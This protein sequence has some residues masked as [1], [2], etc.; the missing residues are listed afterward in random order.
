MKVLLFSPFSSIWTHSLLENQLLKL[1]PKSQGFEK[2]VVNCGSVYPDYCTSRL[3]AGLSLESAD[4]DKLNICNR[5]SF[6]ANILESD[7]Q[8]LIIR[9][10]D[11]MQKEDY[12]TAKKAVQEID[13]DKIKENSFRGFKIGGTSLYELILTNKKRNLELKEDE[14]NLFK[15]YIY[16]SVLTLIVA[17]RILMDV[18]P[19]CVIIYN[20]QYAIPSAFAMMAESMNTKIYYI[21]GVSNLREIQST[22]S[23]FDWPKL[24]DKGSPAREY[25]SSRA[26]FMN[27]SFKKRVTKHFENI[28]K[29]TSGWVYSSKKSDRSTREFFQ[30]RKNEKIILAILSSN[31]EYFAAY[32]AGMREYVP[33]NKV[34]VYETQ[35]EWIKNLIDKTKKMENVVLIIR[36]HPRELPNKREQVVSE[37]LDL[38]NKFFQPIPNHVRLDHPNLRFSLM[39]HFAEVD[40]VTVSWSSTAME[41]L[42]RGIPVV[43]YDERLP[44]YP[45]DLYFSGKTE[46]TYYSNLEKALAMERKRIS[47]DAVIEWLAFSQLYGAVRLGGRWLDRSLLKFPSFHGFIP[48]LVLYFFSDSIKKIE[49]FIPPIKKDQKKLI[50]LILERKDSF[51]E[52]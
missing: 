48:R 38:L 30:I 6:N 50:K 42:Y 26:K 10:K 36:I 49:S 18:K 29:A 39:D 27:K 1:L 12:G 2:I 24:R 20:P 17:E 22:L 35:I 45:P 43:A 14:K 47:N 41:A 9:M 11:Y 19:D 3:H 16:N 21:Q 23:I 40:V 44:N 51:Y 37:Q 31:D 52:Q 13:F 15:T 28:E 32:V 34:L 25:W 5:C 46:D 4:V 7:G 33:K 8:K